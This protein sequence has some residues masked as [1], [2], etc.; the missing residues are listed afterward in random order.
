[1][2]PRLSHLLLGVAVTSFGWQAVTAQSSDEAA[3][4]QVAHAG[5]LPNGGNGWWEPGEGRPIPEAIEY[6]NDHGRL[7]LYNVDGEVLTEGHPFFEPIGP[8]GRACVSC[9]QPADGMSLSLRSIRERWEETGGSD[10]IFAAIDGANCPNLPQG[11]EASHSLLL[12]RGLFRIGLPWPPRDPWGDGTIE[13]EFTLEVVRDPGGCN[14]DPEYGLDSANPTVSV[15]RRPRM[16]ANLPYVVH[17]NFGIGPFV[18]KTG[19]PALRDP[20]NGEPVNMNLMA[21]ARVPT[22]ATQAS[23][24]AATHLQLLRAMTPAELAQITDM[25]GQLFAAQVYDNVAGDLLAGPGGNAFGP[26]NLAHGDIGFLG[27]NTTRWVFP[28]AAEWAEPLPELT[29]EQNER[30]ASIW[31]GQQIYHF[32]TFWISDS[33]HLNS[34]GLGNPV[35]RTCATCHGMH[36]TGLDT[37]NGWMDIGTTNLPWAREVPQNP[38]TDEQELMPLFRI[39][40]R[41]DVP[42]HPFLGRVIYTQDPGRALISGRCND[43]GT[44][45]MQQFR[46]FA[47]RAPYFSN[48]SAA[49]IREVIDFYD[50]RYNIQ[51]SEQEKTD[52]EN[53]LATL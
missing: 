13:P 28:V 50:R 17:R 40:C 53:F 6:E 38:W 31:R 12:E 32:R 20:E 9:H 24:A 42:P 4:A 5:E 45:V 46:A 19:E 33:M 25:Q 10:P 11:E 21:D 51:Y 37:A 15:Y 47:S 43:V 23:D 3:A 1:M 7:R 52:L 27:N 36:M 44:I 2:K 8:N 22:L 49:N 35:K 16:V 39:T 34:V 29:D 26:E 48:G 14:T 30:R 41:D 18:G